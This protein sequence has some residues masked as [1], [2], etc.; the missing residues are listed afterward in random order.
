MNGDDLTFVQFIR[1]LKT[2]YRVSEG[3]ANALQVKGATSTKVHASRGQAGV[4]ATTA[5]EEP[6][7]KGVRHGVGWKQQGQRAPQ[8]FYPQPNGSNHA[9]RATTSTSGCPQCSHD[10][11]LEVCRGYLGKSLEERRMICREKHLCFRCLEPNHMAFRCQS[12]VTCGKC[13]E[14]H[15]YTIHGAKRMDDVAQGS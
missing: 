8:M 6:A 5:E 14:R 7:S 9:N 13:G 12:R 10:H 4:A 15:R 3:V 2:H 11:H 1:F